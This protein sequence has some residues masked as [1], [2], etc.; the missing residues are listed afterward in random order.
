[1]DQ[2][3]KVPHKVRMEYQNSILYRCCA[4]NVQQKLARKFSNGTG[5][6]NVSMR[7]FSFQSPP[8]HFLPVTKLS[9]PYHRPSLVF[10]SRM[11]KKKS[12]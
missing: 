5:K 10:F 2:G 9:A 1:M 7:S 8:I 11:Q 6:S 12:A 4:I 3:Q